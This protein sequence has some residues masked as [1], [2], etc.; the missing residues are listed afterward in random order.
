MTNTGYQKKENARIIDNNARAEERIR[1]YQE[2][3][4][5]KQARQQA[6]ALPA[7][8]DIAEEFEEGLNADQLEQ[9]TADQATLASMMDDPEGAYPEGELPIDGYDESEIPPDA[10]MFADTEAADPLPSA[11]MS[12]IVQ[13]AQAQAEQ[14]LAEMS[15]D[16]K[17]SQMIIPFV[18]RGQMPP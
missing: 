6:A 10:G 14:I 13:D 16:E 3:Q 7:F 15:L 18:K 1:A 4:M 17:I 8:D 5:R 2:E 12:A 9:L 11:D